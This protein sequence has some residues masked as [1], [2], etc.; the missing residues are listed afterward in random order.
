MGRVDF[1][2]ETGTGIMSKA[3]AL[4]MMTGSSSSTVKGKGEHTKPQLKKSDSTLT[5]KGIEIEPWGA[6]NDEPQKIITAIESIPIAGRALDFNIKSFYGAGPFIHTVDYSDDGKELISGVNLEGKGNDKLKAFLKRSRFKK[7]NLELITDNE[8]FFNVFPEM[9]VSKDY[10]S[11]V[12]MGHQE[13]A[14]CRWALWDKTEKRITKCLISAN[15]EDNPNDENVDVVDV[16]DPKLTVDEVREWLKKKKIYKFIYPLNYPTPGQ[17]YYKVPY[18]NGARKAGWFDIAAKVPEFKKKIMENQIAIRWIIKIPWSYW[19]NEFPKA[20]FKNEK[21]RLDKIGEKLD[22]MEDFI[23]NSTN[24][25]KAM[26]TH[27]DIDKVTQKAL[28]GIEITPIHS[29][30]TGE[31]GLYLEDS[32]AANSE[33]LFAFGVDGTLIGAGTPGGKREG[34]GGSDKREAY[35]LKSALHKAGRDLISEAWEFCFEFNGFGENL[36]VGFKDIVFTTLDKNPTGVQKTI[37]T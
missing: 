34:G 35:F 14:F 33:I 24:A 16:V 7:T 5:F 2:P 15:W 36:K 18:W 29:K 31:D 32:S 4:V 37:G 27:F 3:G 26:V 13:A 9:I 6:D 10:K 28:P 30:I 23:C 21:E 1:N 19:E 12:S 25:G 22:E 8:T 20:V 17:S 11:I